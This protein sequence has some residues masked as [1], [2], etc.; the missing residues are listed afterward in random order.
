ML[1]WLYCLLLSETNTRILADGGRVVLEHVHF[2]E[3][4]KAEAE[5][6]LLGG[7][8]GSGGGGSFLL[9]CDGG[10]LQKLNCKHYNYRLSRRKIVDHLPNSAGAAAVEEGETALEGG[11]TALE[12][13]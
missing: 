5:S 8:V 13:G 6:K 4:P 2:D 9:E 10:V 11:E 12:E 7:R 1:T 3:R